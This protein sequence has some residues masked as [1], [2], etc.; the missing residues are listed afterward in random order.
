MNWGKSAAASDQGMRI[1][2]RKAGGEEETFGGGA[3]GWCRVGAVAQE[4][5]CGAG[6]KQGGEG[7][8][9][10]GF[11]IEIEEVLVEG[12]GVFASE[13]V[14]GDGEGDQG[15]GGADDLG[16]AA[17]VEGDFVVGAG[18]L[19]FCVGGFEKGGLLGPVIGGGMGADGVL[20]G[21][22]HTLGGA[23]VGGVGD[24]GPGDAVGDARMRAFIGIAAA[25]DS[26]FKG[27]HLDPHRGIG[28]LGRGG[29][30]GEQHEGEERE[31]KLPEKFG[32]TMRRSFGLSS[33]KGVHP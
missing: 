11:G 8:D 1:G 15:V 33:Q 9:F 23:G 13:A 12:G 2:G 29:A 17:V 22:V 31:W 18:V 26:A 14:F 27:A 30:G 21:L 4:L 32:H 7:D 6:G 28:L 3:K 19:K 24:F 20:D 16:D 25:L 10:A 5:L